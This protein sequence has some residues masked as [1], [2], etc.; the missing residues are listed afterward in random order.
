MTHPNAMSGT[1]RV[2][3][4]NVND[5]S[6]LTRSRQL[7]S[8]CGFPADACE[9]IVRDVENARRKYTDRFGEAT[10]RRVIHSCLHGTCYPYWMQR[11][12]RQILPGKRLF[13]QDS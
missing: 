5:R 12:R 4:V 6:H 7:W 8:K 2:L 3:A 13:P 11:R 10:A 1:F 9:A